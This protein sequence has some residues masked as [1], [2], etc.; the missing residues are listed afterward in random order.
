MPSFVDVWAELRP[1]ERGITFD[2]VGNLMFPRSARKEQMRYDRIVYE[3]KK[4]SKSKEN[5]KEKSKSKS[6]AKS[7]SKESF[8]AKQIEIVGDQPSPNNV[9]GCPILVSDHYGLV[10]HF[11]RTN[12]N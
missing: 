11:E 4:L 2:S 3:S 12:A 9:A 7:K 6:K 10:A 5:S 8:V 1:N